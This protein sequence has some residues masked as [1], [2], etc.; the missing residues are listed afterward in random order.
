MV[1]NVTDKSHK[2]DAKLRRQRVEEESGYL[3]SFE[4][5]LKIKNFKRKLLSS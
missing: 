5:L 1:I 2:V 4:V 3:H